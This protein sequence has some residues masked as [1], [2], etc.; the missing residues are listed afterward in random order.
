GAS[1]LLTPLLP[2]FSPRVKSKPA[3][4]APPETPAASICR[5]QSAPPRAKVGFRPPEA[6][7]D[8]M[9][10]NPPSPPPRFADRLTALLWPKPAG[11][12]GERPRRRVVVYLVPFLFCLYILAYLDRVN[13]SVAK[14]GMQHPPSEGGL[15]INE[16]VLG[17]GA[18][19]FFWGY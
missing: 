5:L 8:P 9:T 14:L 15:G 11:A 19:I 4:A 3:G 18:G 2:L 6:P 1:P 7:Q 13:A 10:S 12:L 16:K 17:F